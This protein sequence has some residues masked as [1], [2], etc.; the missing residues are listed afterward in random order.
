MPVTLKPISSFLQFYKKTQLGF[1]AITARAVVLTLAKHRHTR[2]S[3][4]ILMQISL[5]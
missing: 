3:N 4:A 2:L 1:T 5:V